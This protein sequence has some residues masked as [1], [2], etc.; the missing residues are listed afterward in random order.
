MKRVYWVCYLTLR[1]RSWKVSVKFLIFTICLI[2]HNNLLFQYFVSRTYAKFPK[3]ERI[4]QNKPRQ[5]YY[6][7]SCSRNSKNYTS[8][9]TFN[10]FHSDSRKVPG[11]KAGV[12]TVKMQHRV[13]LEN[14]W[15]T[16]LGFFVILSARRFMVEASAELKFRT[17][18][19]A[20]TAHVV[21]ELPTTRK[22]WSRHSAESRA[23]YNFVAY[24]KRIYIY[25]YPRGPEQTT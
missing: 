14:S 6:N 3:S 25:I 21:S 8:D 18:N 9:V 10:H 19:E 1:E 22:P 16:T 12:L 11:I 7:S 2:N 24:S 17:T 5:H 13:R 20:D 15:C 4:A 23:K